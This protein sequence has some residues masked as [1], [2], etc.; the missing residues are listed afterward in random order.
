MAFAVA[1]FSAAPIWPRCPFLILVGNV[2]PKL[3][4]SLVIWDNFFPAHDD[5]FDGLIVVA[6]VVVDDD[7]VFKLEEPAAM[8]CIFTMTPSALG[9]SALSEG[10]EDDADIDVDVF[11]V[12]VDVVG[13]FDFFLLKACLALKPAGVRFFFC[14]LGAALRWR[15][16]R[17]FGG[18]WL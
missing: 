2:A 12:I 11:D 17:V 5:F 6:I 3:S 15:G 10:D 13:F 18:S 14:L 7:E 8:F 9:L 4:N 16:G 1:S